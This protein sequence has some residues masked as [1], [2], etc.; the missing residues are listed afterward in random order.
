MEGVES[1]PLS[2]EQENVLDVVFPNVRLYAVAV[3]PWEFRDDVIAW[4]RCQH[5]PAGVFIIVD[6]RTSENEMRV[7]LRRYHSHERA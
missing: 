4:R 1:S 7:A 6:A 2:S 3:G 5:G